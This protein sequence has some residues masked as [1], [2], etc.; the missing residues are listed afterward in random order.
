MSTHTPPDADPTLDREEREL[1]A[2]YRQLPAIEPDAALD[3]RV[4]DAARGAVTRKP[5]RYSKWLAGFGSAATLVMAAGLTWHLY[6]R[7]PGKTPQSPAPAIA[8]KASATAARAGSQVVRV[9]ILSERAP[10][11]SDD[12]LKLMPGTPAATGRE[13][14]LGGF[15]ASPPPMAKSAAPASPQ[16]VD[17]ASFL[18]EQARRALAQ[19]DEARART[20]VHELLT[21]YPGTTLPPDLSRLKP[22]NDKPGTP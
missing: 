14:N 6:G 9:R 18:I 19:E 20:L 7:G 2:L 3:A 1:A 22:A 8:H 12:A 13:Q 21:R 11:A 4:L 5:R 17:S 10:A 15:A 16:A